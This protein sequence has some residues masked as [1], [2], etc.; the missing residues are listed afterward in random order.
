MCDLWI[1][2]ESALHEPN[3]KA[4]SKQGKGITWVSVV[5]AG[6]RRAGPDGIGI[7]A[8][9]RCFL[10]DHRRNFIHRGNPAHERHLISEDIQ[11]NNRSSLW[12]FLSTMLGRAISA[13]CSSRKARSGSPRNDNQ[14]KL[15]KTTNN[16]SCKSTLACEST[17][18]NKRLTSRQARDRGYKQIRPLLKKQI[19]ISDLPLRDVQKSFSEGISKRE[20]RRTIL[21]VCE[22]YRKNLYFLPAICVIYKAIDGPDVQVSFVVDGK[23]SPPHDQAF[24]QADGTHLLHIDR[25][26]TRFGSVVENFEMIEQEVKE[27]LTEAV[28][29]GKT[30]QQGEVIEASLRPVGDPESWSLLTAEQQL[31]LQ[32]AG[33]TTSWI[34]RLKTRGTTPGDMLTSP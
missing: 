32:Q 3:R 15:P 31:E 30:N 8:E 26:L 16:S 10:E 28:A 14:L 23:H 34:T 2:S 21:S 4:R 18:L 5:P 7:R 33:L 12:N 27:A 29:S 1:R 11:A 6:W 25:D 22:L 24:A 13:L 9:V 17:F 19:G 20:T